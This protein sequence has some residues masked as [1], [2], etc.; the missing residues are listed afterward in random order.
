MK[1][2]FGSLTRYEKHNR[3]TKY[4]MVNCDI[5]S[6]ASLRCGTE[7]Y[8]KNRLSLLMSKQEQ[9]FLL[10]RPPGAGSSSGWGEDGQLG[11]SSVVMISWLS[12]HP[13]GEKRWESFKTGGRN[14]S[15]LCL[16]FPRRVVYPDDRTSFR[17]TS[18]PSRG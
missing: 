13:A 9:R 16:C 8:Q 15:P 6:L 5:H 11:Y 3:L 14:T 1:G 12:S 7:E 10:S 18:P 17:H 2:K 4:R